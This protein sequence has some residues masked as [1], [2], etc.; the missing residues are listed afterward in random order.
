MECPEKSYKCSGKG[1]GK[2]RTFSEIQAK[3]KAG[4]A[5][6]L[7][8]EEV[9]SRVRAGEKVE[10]ED[11]DVITTATRGIMSGT[12]AVLSFKV[13]EP[14][15]F[16]RASE[17][18]LNGIPA[19]VGPC[20]NERLGILD[21]IVLGTARSKTDPRYGGGH[22]LRELVEGK[23]IS[24]AVKPAASETSP[25]SA[26]FSIKTSLS[27]MPFARLYAT[28]HAFKNYKAFVNPGKEALN[29]IFHVLPF[30]GDFQE[31]TFCGCGALNPLENDPHLESIGIGTRVL[32]NGAEGF[33]TGY[34]TRSSKNNPNLAGFAEL[35]NME[36]E[37]MG[38]FVSSEGPEIINT[39][40]VPLPILNPGMLENILKLDKEI[41]L[42]LVDLAGRT[43]LCEIS[44]GD[45][46]DE[47]D[48]RVRY[49][50]KACLECKS[51]ELLR[52]CPMEAIKKTKTGKI[53]HIRSLCFNCGLCVS[54]CR[55]GAF[56]AKLGSV[57]CLIEGSLKDIQVTLRQSDRARAQKA[58][59]ELKNKVLSGEFRIKEAV[60]KIKFD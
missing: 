15:N 51:C 40:A 56:K 59:K 33:V 11:V 7:T 38:G 36:P 26:P 48:L 43:P 21:L 42:Q 13:A 8:A 9:A 50:P 4:K 12:Y 19:V 22:L 49:E 45:V 5:V 32:I 34:G 20:P 28:R 52:L 57:H 1:F 30:K 18:S 41:P 10:F 17:V 55:G 47:A 6:V 14:D 58:A 25:A 39:W 27:E 60:E 29:T 31:M 23:T 3:I 37:Y 53:K 2:S 24:V 54:R 44:Y 35:R 46:W 16:I